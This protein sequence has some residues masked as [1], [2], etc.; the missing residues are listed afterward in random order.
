MGLTPTD[1]L[2]AVLPVEAVLIATAENQNANGPAQSSVGPFGFE[3]R[4]S[5]DPSFWPESPRFAPKFLDPHRFPDLFPAP[6]RTRLEA[7]SSGWEAAELHRSWS[8]AA[9]SKLRPARLFELS[10]RNCLCL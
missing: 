1:G 6:A 2:I 10:T 4:G 7:E 9:R 8:K 5:C 3:R